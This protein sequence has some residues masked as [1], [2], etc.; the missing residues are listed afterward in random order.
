MATLTE[1]L[2]NA[3]LSSAQA[4]VIAA[5]FSNSP[6]STQAFQ[7]A[8][9]LAGVDAEAAVLLAANIGA[10]LPEGAVGAASFDSQGQLLNQ[11]GEVVLTGAEVAGAKAVAADYVYAGA[12]RV[13]AK[14]IPRVAVFGNSLARNQ[15]T[16]QAAGGL[17]G[18]TRQ[19]TLFGAWAAW[20]AALT[21]GACAFDVYASEGYSGFTTDQVLAAAQAANATETFGASE[22]I[23]IGIAARAPEIV[24]VTPPTNDLFTTTLADIQSGAAL[25][26]AIAGSRATW[27]YIRACGGVP[28]QVSMMP[29]QGSVAGSGGV[30]GAQCA[31]YVDAWNS[32]LSVVAKADDVPWVDA[33]TPCAASGGGWKTGYIYKNGADDATGLHPSLLASIEIGKACAPVIKAVIETSPKVPR[34]Y[35]GAN[36]IYAAEFVAGSNRQFFNNPSDPLFQSVTSFSDRFDP[37][38]DSTSAVHT[39]TIDTAGGKTVNVKKPTAT[40]TAYA[41]R[42]YPTTM[43]VAAGQEYLIAVDLQILSADSLTDINFSV[44]DDTTGSASRYQP[45]VFWNMSSKNAP[46]AVPLDSGVH[47]AVLHLRVPTGVTTVRPFVVFNRQAG[48]SAGGFDE[49]RVANIIALRIA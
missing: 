20:A 30:T 45:M 7:E 34:G 22:T 3:G 26:R 27:A 19:V 11:S 21:D 42:Q 17:V 33:Y 24:F 1:A 40:G 28:I 44:I 37:Q 10:V 12:S 14:R 25:Q 46:P 16:P 49:I 35:L 9:I 6:P 8:L 15:Y 43:T 13:R 39:P 32:A 38:S 48:G 36:P 31:P 47:R 18:A 29:M 2:I 41:D 4:N 23:P 5:R